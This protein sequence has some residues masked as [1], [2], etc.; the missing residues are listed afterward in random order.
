MSLSSPTNHTNYYILSCVFNYNNHINTFHIR[1]ESICC[2][3]YN[4]SKQYII[5]YDETER[6]HQDD[7]YIS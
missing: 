3:F 7:F 1:F 5:N 6:V 2:S 4:E